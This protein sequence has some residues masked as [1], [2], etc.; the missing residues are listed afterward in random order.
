[1][2]HFAPRSL[3]R[4]LYLSVS[5]LLI[6]AVLASTWNTNAQEDKHEPLLSWN[7]A[8]LVPRHRSQADWLVDVGWKTFDEVY[9]PFPTYEYQVEDEEQFIP[10]GYFQETAK[11]F[12]LRY[13]SEH[14][15]FWFERGTPV[16]PVALETTA[17]FFEEHIWPLNTSLFG[18]A[19]SPGIDG[20]SRLHIINQETIEPG[21]MGAFNPQDQCPRSICPTSN[22]REI[23]YISLDFAPLNSEEYLTTLAHEHQHL[24][25][26]HV[27]GNETR[28]LNEGLSQLAEHL[29]GFHPR[30]IGG[31]NLVDFLRAPDHYLN[32]WAENEFELA[33][34]YGA[35]YLFLV[36]L[37]ERFGIDF[38][39]QLASSD[40]DG[41]AAVQ[42]TLAE[43]VPT[44]S[45][46]D[47][48]ADW[49]IANYLD[50]PYAG[51]GLYYYQS[52]DLPAQIRPERLEI[53]DQP[54]TSTVNP[55]G[56]HYLSLNDPGTY[57]I[58]FDGS[59]EAALLDTQPRSKDWMWWSYNSEN[60]AA[61]LTG[62]FD[63][64]G[65][66]TA[67]LKFSLWWDTEEE[68][69][70]FQ[71]L[72]SGNGGQDW[73]IIAG[74]NAKPND[75]PEA[76]GA[77]YTGLS[78]NWVDERID[79]SDYVGGSVLIR[80]EYL[81]DFA[82]TTAGV[83]LDDIGIEELGGLDDTE[84]AGASVWNPEGFMRISGTVPQSWT[85]AMIEDQRGETAAIDHLMLDQMN[86]GR[87]TVTVPEGGRMTLVIGAMVPF[88][89]SRA[90]Y[91]LTIQPHEGE[92]KPEG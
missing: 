14:A 28:W 24:I 30:Y 19:W 29:N 76:P 42:A 90:F 13:R 11:P 22:Q 40:Y 39:R 35:G 45:V 70:W 26:H 62:A 59:D 84:I 60:G 27:D 89:S 37:Y 73:A 72:A 16:D 17:R 64:S 56:A 4:T 5:L 1:M 21:V 31:E 77:H 34:Y 68:S 50:D 85:V 61:R 25:Q 20:D 7:D 69:D 48:F 67:T 10:L 75:G 92:N 47:V 58:S 81:T 78:P 3:R 79:L 41:L 80:F 83:A 12:Y 52:M 33:R 32:G 63:L 87:A 43:M 15:Y 9:G 2:V 36:Y 8:P 55:Y 57:D 74:E 82:T 49:I 65:L 66:K 88:S 53:N 38:I 44:L 54:Y 91:K 6:A 23:I 18:E 51:S 46:D 71:I 86:T